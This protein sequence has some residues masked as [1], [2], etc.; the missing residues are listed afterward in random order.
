MTRG[1]GAKVLALLA[2]VGALVL[3]SPSPAQAA[4][5]GAVVSRKL[6]QQQRFP[7]D[8]FD[9]S[10]MAGKANGKR[11]GGQPDPMPG[12]ANPDIPNLSVKSASMEGELLQWVAW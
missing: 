2:V 5:L 6:Q 12:L 3:L 4:P 9:R 10:S 8:A 11:A 1:S 7:Y